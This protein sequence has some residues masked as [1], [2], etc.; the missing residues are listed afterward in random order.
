MASAKKT[1]NPLTD[2]PSNK[3]EITKPFMLAY[4]REV[5]TAEDK[6]WFKKIVAD[7]NNQK[8]YLNKLNGT[9]YIDIDIPKVRKE[10]ISRFFP[11]LNAKK[12]KNKT[13]IDSILDLQAGRKILCKRFSTKSRVA[14]ESR[15]DSG[16]DPLIAES[17]GGQNGMR[18]G[19]A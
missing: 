16:L 1:L 10:F 14:L 6:E 8:E 13:F 3:V 5:A 4:M 7:K 19:T 18:A 12:E 11:Q 15:A 17:H 9:T 2:T